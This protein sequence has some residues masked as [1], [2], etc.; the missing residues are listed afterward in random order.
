[1]TPAEFLCERHPAS[2]RAVVQ[3]QAR[4]HGQF[5]TALWE[6][7]ASADDK[8]LARLEKG[9]PDEVAGLR[10]WRFGDLAERL[11]QLGLPV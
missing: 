2:E 4:L 5:Y 1:M 11:R 3:W 9:F 8:N 10:S 6:A 7:L